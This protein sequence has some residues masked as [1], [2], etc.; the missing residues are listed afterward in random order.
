MA[1]GAT[2]ASSVELGSAVMASQVPVFPQVGAVGVGGR[3]V[4]GFTSPD[5]RTLAMYTAMQN[6]A[7]VQALQGGMFPGVPGPA[8]VVSCFSLCS[9]RLRCLGVCFYS[10]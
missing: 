4:A 3:A 1:N 8:G 2:A 7:A 9:S 6:S 10:Q 5:P